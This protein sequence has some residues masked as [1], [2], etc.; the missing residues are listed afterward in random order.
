MVEVAV[1]V[2]HPRERPVP[3]R[4]WLFAFIGGHWLR[5][6]RGGDKFFTSA[7]AWWYAAQI[8]AWAG[9]LPAPDQLRGMGG[10]NG[11]Q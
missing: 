9:V 8:E 4:E 2:F 10:K 6:F 5:G 1:S 7:T 3:E 11:D